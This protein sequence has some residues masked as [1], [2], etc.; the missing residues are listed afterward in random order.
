LL[1]SVAFWGL[2]VGTPNWT[3][4]LAK[5]RNILRQP[6][7][8]GGLTQF[9]PLLHKSLLQ[10]QGGIIG[11]A[12]SGWTGRWRG[13]R[14]DFASAK[15][16]TEGFQTQNFREIQLRNPVIT[17]LDLVSNFRNANRDPDY[18]LAF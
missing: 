13:C 10:S 4:N 15:T 16:E 12:A 18:P 14:R 2:K 3:P 11:V 6:M 5:N 17:Y 9:L 8:A 1:P 7:R